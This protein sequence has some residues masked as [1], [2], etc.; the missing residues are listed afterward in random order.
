MPRRVYNKRSVRTGYE[1][2]TADNQPKVNLLTQPRTFAPRDLSQKI[3]AVFALWSALLSF[4][5]ACATCGGLYM[6]CNCM[7]RTF[8]KAWESY[9]YGPASPPVQCITAEVASCNNSL[10]VTVRWYHLARIL[11]TPPP[12]KH[13]G[14]S[15]RLECNYTS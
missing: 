2:T 14:D 13:L 1:H 9:S 8:D 5:L 10:L 12:I 15:S 11:P 3:R 4:Y 6:Y 7:Q